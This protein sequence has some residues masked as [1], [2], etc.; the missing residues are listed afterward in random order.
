MASLATLRKDA[1]A[2]GIPASAIRRATSMEELQELIDS[3]NDDE[4]TPRNRRKVVRKKVRKAAATRKTAPARKTRAA[5][6]KPAVKSTRGKAKRSTAGS[7][8]NGYIPKDARNLL[9]GVNYSQTDGWN[10][11]EGSP[12]DRIIRAL[13]AAK[14]N[15]ERAFDK[16]VSDLWDFVGRKM[17]NGTKRTKESAENMLRYRISRTAWDFAL[18]T[19]QHEIAG[20]RVEYGTGGTGQGLY[21][22]RRKAAPVSRKKAS[23]RKATTRKS[24]A[25]K[26]APVARKATARKTAPRK[27]TARKTAARKTRSRR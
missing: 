23:A 24:A 15:R 3:Y 5:K 20:N 1:K 11:R 17:A 16:L 10:P 12:P 18:R 13:R 7:N 22:P 2:A 19:G 8:T 6:S 26:T 27:T 25:R 14:G 9:E 4:P 21:K